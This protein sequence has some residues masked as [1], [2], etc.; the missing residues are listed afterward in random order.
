M[1]FE[2]T[3]NLLTEIFNKLVIKR[4]FL[5]DSFDSELNLKNYYK[6]KNAVEK[7]DKI[8]FHELY[9]SDF[10]NTNLA[11][12]TMSTER[13]LCIA[14][15]AKVYTM[16]P[17]A[18]QLI[19]LENI[20][21]R[22]I[23]NYTESN[24][25]Y[26]IICGLP[27]IG[28]SIF[29][30]ADESYKD[31][32]D[33]TKPLHL[34][35][36]SD[37]LKLYD[38]GFLQKLSEKYPNMQYINY[39][40]RRPSIIEARDAAD[41]SI[42]RMAEIKGADDICDMFQET[43]QK[44]MMTFI[45][46]HH[47]MFYQKSTD[48]YESLICMILIW[49]TR[50]DVLRQIHA[51]V[52]VDYY[53]DYDLAAIFEDYSLKI[54]DSIS[55]EIRSDIAKNINLLVR[56]RGTNEVLKNLSDIFGI[57][58]IYNYIIQKIYVNGEPT[59]RCHA[60]PVND[61]KNIK[62][63]L[64]REYGY[65]SYGK[66]VQN[67]KTWMD[68]P[69]SNKTTKSITEENSEYVN[70]YN[71]LLN[72]DFSW[73][74][75]KYV[76]VDNIIDMSQ[77]SL[78]FSMFF[79]YLLNYSNVYNNIM[80]EHKIAN[81]KI[82]LIQTYAYLCSLLSSK[83]HFKDNIAA[84]TSEIK[85]VL[86]LNDKVNFKEIPLEKLKIK[87]V[88]DNPDPEVEY[89]DVYFPAYGT[90]K[91]YI[92]GKIY[93]SINKSY[94]IKRVV[95]GSIA[96]EK[97]Y[98]TEDQYIQTL[99]YINDKLSTA[100]LNSPLI[101]EIWVPLTPKEVITYTSQTNYIDDK[102]STGVQA[103]VEYKYLETKETET[104]YETLN[105]YIDDKIST[106]VVAYEKEIVPEDP[107]TGGNTGGGTGTGSHKVFEVYVDITD[108]LRLF[109]CNFSG[110][111]YMYI[112]N[113]WISFNPDGTFEEF[114][115]TFCGDRNLIFTFKNIMRETVDIGQYNTAKIA[116]EYA[117]RLAAKTNLYG[118]NT[119]YSDFLKNTSPLLYSYYV[120]LL[121][122]DEDKWSE[123]F[124]DEIVYVL[125][126][127][128]ELIDSLDNENYKEVFNFLEDIRDTQINELK[129]V[130]SYLVGYFTSMTVTIRDPEFKYELGDETDNYSIK[131]EMKKTMS[132]RK[133]NMFN[134]TY[135]S[136][137]IQRSKVIP[138]EMFVIRE[139]LSIKWNKLKE[140]II[141]TGGNNE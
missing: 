111:S 69:L 138:K 120:G 2:R 15:P 129:N 91:Y 93:L 19:V 63:Y 75:S 113:N 45:R 34:M 43:Y 39:L 89:I 18:Q 29:F 12:E 46:R 71:M 47:N 102:I 80:V 83:Y 53:D 62:K 50:I 52:D 35:S 23:N 59:I 72:K 61:M 125:S 94:E 1:N 115:D 137:S 139:I 70:T 117:T 99:N 112:L 66:L 25:Y 131:D 56:N 55:K 135:D 20:R 16:L 114:I 95:K 5:A 26:R 118:T 100:I 109:E 106:S 67:D 134:E 37:L 96:V 97:A 77:M 74:H 76:A 79:N 78:D 108:L 22:I 48:Y 36:D 81:T 60:V 24:P 30:Y 88:I 123:V 6:Y 133:L 103:S 116:Y 33:I 110:T 31:Y 84:N 38:L 27:P 28:E 7:N 130:L 49:A 82:N 21:A 92:D 140:T 73:I 126:L 85:Y 54:D 40:H 104:I 86:A 41:F 68:R 122:T 87:T 105:N 107:G 119:T 101:K 8:E 10:A 128:R 14:T 42:I 32:V 44:N 121:K 58:N 141:G 9:A 90:V 124:S 57:K 11:L 13:R 127:L 136:L 4:G 3:E 64:S 17:E 65:I 51:G 132:D 98:L